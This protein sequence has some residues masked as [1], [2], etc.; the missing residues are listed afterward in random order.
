MR[1]TPRRICPA[2]LAVATIAN[3]VRRTGSGTGAAGGRTL[4]TAEARAARSTRRGRQPP[5][6]RSAQ[7][8]QNR[9]L[10]PAPDG[11]AAIREGK[12][13]RPLVPPFRLRYA[14]ALVALALL[15]RQVVPGAVAYWRLYAV[16]TEFANYGLCMAGPTGP[17]LLADRPAEF[18]R[19]V[20]RR[21]VSA[22]AESRPFARCLEPL[23]SL[24]VDERTLRA[25]RG[26]ARQFEEFGAI[27]IVDEAPLALDHLKVTAARLEQLAAAAWPFSG[28]EYAELI[29]ASRNARTAAHPVAPAE[30]SVG[31]GL[32]RAL[33]GFRGVVPTEDG[34]LLVV[35]RDANRQAYR[36]LD[37][38]RTWAAVSPYSAE[39]ERAQGSCGEGAREA[40]FRISVS[41]RRIRIESWAG[42]GLETSFPLAPA[43]D[44]LLEFS[45]DSGVALTVTRGRQRSLPSVQ[46]C[47]HLR[48][49]HSLALPEDL[50]GA[51]PGAGASI[52][53]ARIRGT[54]VLAY[55]RRGIVR[56]ASSRDDGSSWTPPVVAYDRREYP[57]LEGPLPDRLLAIGDRVLLYAGATAGRSSYPVLLSSDRGASWGAA[58]PLRTASR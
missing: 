44:E 6:T 41:E 45:C 9:R 22:P 11:T 33:S 1:A 36:S 8:R 15:A 24:S 39:A 18:W 12:A 30:P 43:D 48:R 7:L 2:F 19:L 13:V 34:H 28:G 32:S 3:M 20:R 25:H 53:V 40:E 37:G 27:G 50:Q 4:E 17:G 38:G 52:S 46:L 5:R 31:H 16:A 47:P 29:R 10:S 26:R 35:G 58:D 55:S 42:G 21:L 14:V 51:D 57:S 23:L 56:V 54:T 49:C